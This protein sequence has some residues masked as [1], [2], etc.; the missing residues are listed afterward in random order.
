VSFAALRNPRLLPWLW[1][2]SLY[3]V[4][5]IPNSLVEKVGPVFLKDLG[6]DEVL[7]P[8]IVATAALPWAL[9]PFWSP[10][11]DLYK[12]KRLWVWVFQFLLAGTFG[13]LAL[14][15]AQ[16]TTLDSLLLVLATIAFLSATHDIAAD[17]FYLHG[18]GTTAQTYFVGIR[19][20]TYRLATILGQSLLIGAVGVLVKRAAWP[21]DDAWASVFAALAVF[22]FALAVYHRA[23]LPRPAS[24]VPVSTAPTALFREYLTTWR[25]FFAQRGIVDL[26][27]FFLF[28]RLAEVQLVRITPLFLK[29]ER[30]TGALSL[31]NETVALVYGTFGT[32]AL[33]VG[34]IL[35]GILAAR[36]G[37]RKLIWP[38]VFIMH[39]PNLA[40][41][42]LA[43]WQPESTAW[44]SAGIV[45]EQF[46]YGLG[47]TAFSIV[48][49]RIGNGP[50][51][52]AHFAFATGLAY[53]GNLIPGFWVGSLVKYLGYESFF[54]WVILCTLPGLAVTWLVVVRKKET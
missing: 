22:T 47:Y 15:V 9:K 29:G 4:E 10:L 41:I 36:Y 38:I 6:A 2:P 14:L 42:A 51:R 21:A 52:A 1:V 34:G 3:L 27:L 39:T 18:L 37:L 48:M 50:R 28:F 8:A 19:S 45:L 54:W 35:G 20:S 49:L 17:G 32:G 26:I 31:D 16:G 5:G 24:D 23:V 43:H 40:F 46:G 13:A 53:L 30:A 12:T 7:I 25:E 44:V 33:M 11:V